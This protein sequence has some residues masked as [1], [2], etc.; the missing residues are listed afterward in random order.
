[1]ISVRIIRNDKNFFILEY[2][3][4]DALILVLIQGCFT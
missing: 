2:K 4:P 1:M 3:K